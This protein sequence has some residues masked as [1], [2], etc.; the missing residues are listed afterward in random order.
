M[1]LRILIG[2]F[3]LLPFVA[4]AAVPECKETNY[5][6]CFSVRGRY[7]IYADG[8]FMWIVGTKRMLYTT[9]DT[10]DKMLEEVGWEEHVLFGDFTVCPTSSY[11]KG[12]MQGACIQTYSH[13]KMSKRP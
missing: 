4:H 9:D 13:I 2:F 1:K 12:E 3:I 8:D 7:A 6:K 11:K 10:L 5:G